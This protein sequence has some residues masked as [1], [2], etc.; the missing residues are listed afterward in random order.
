M[1]VDQSR[2]AAHPAVA[3]GGGANNALVKSHDELHPGR[4][5]EAVIKTGLHG[6][7][8]GK[9]IPG[10]GSLRLSDHQ[11]ATGALDPLGPRLIQCRTG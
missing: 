5:H 1:D 2:L 11:I 3:I 7:G 9:Q 4:V 10:S 8:I 6:T